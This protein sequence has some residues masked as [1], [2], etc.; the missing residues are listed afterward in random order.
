MA[1]SVVRKNE[2]SQGLTVGTVTSGCELCQA[3]NLQ[4]FSRAGLYWRRHH[5]YEFTGTSLQFCI[6]IKSE[7]L[8]G[9]LIRPA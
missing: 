2:I 5:L 7:K 4:S 8:F 9:S 3:G 6:T 1:G